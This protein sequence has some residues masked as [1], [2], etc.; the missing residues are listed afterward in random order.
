MKHYVR[1]VPK[2]AVLACLAAASAGCRGNRSDV[3]PIHLQQNMDFQERGEPQEA[4]P[5]F[6]DGRW[7]RQPP[8]GTVAV[9]LL[10]ED[11]HYWRGRGPDG[12]LADSLPPGV[13]LDEAL[14]QR[15]E[16]R[17]DIYCQPCHGGAGYGDGP[18]TRRGGGFQGVKPANFH[19]KKLGP[20]PL[21][22]LFHV[23]SWGK[24]SMLGYAAQVPVRD[25]WAI[26]AWVR[27]L[28]V[29]HRADAKKLPEGTELVRTVSQ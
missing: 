16:E 14:L 29:A 18:V 1:T 26:A 27:T 3:P 21:G 12:T 2:L 23:A 6:A 4:N 8:E 7:M 25:R 11:D 22:Y 9:G 13:E 5:F 24:A 20:A 10:R 28:Q 19:T 15:G 17:Y